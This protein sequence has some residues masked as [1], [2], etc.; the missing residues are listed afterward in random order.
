MKDVERQILRVFESLGQITH[1]IW[2][3]EPVSS[4]FNMQVRRNWISVHIKNISSKKYVVPLLPTLLLNSVMSNSCDHM[5]K[6]SRKTSCIL[7][8][9]SNT[10]KGTIS[11]YFSQKDS[12]VQIN[13]YSRRLTWIQKSWLFL[14]IGLP[15]NPV[16]LNSSLH[17]S[18][19]HVMP[20]IMA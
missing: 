14:S 11:F 1:I 6:R 19:V 16:A 2:L 15:M 8:T 17:V 18:R 5:D 7:E 9:S 12:R 10:S 20:C 3:Y 13:S 4:L